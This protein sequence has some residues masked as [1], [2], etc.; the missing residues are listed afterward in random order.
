MMGGKMGFYNIP[1][2]ITA[3]V[4]VDLPSA[5]SW[6]KR[7]NK[8]VEKFIG[9]PAH[10]FLEGP[11]FDRDGNLYVVNFAFGQVVKIARDGH[12]SVVCEYDG[13]PN[14]MQVGPDG[15]LYITDRQN[16]VMRLDPGSGSIEPFCDVKELSPGYMGLSDIAIAE[17]GDL[18]ITDQGDSHLLNAVGRMLRVSASG[19]VDVLMEGLPGPNGIVLN[20]KETH[21][22][23]AITY[24]PAVWRGRINPAGGVDKVGVFQHLQGGYSGTDGLAMDRDG[25]L[26]ACHNRM[27]TVWLFDPDG[28]PTYRIR[29]PKASGKKITNCAYGG[30][31]NGTLFMTETETGQI[32]VADAPVPGHHLIGQRS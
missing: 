13:A 6:T 12:A 25:G 3:E 29:S 21:V 9:K 14:G 24:G 4:W 28:E 11:A 8:W 23:V 19:K 26:A 17:N 32:L 2:D 7:T 5:L 31:D 15:L 18:Y 1:K 16:G 22:F 30:P 20:P 27:G 10:S